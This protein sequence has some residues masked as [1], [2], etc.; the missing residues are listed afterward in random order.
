MCAKFARDPERTRVAI[1][2]A[3]ERLISTKGLQA[4]T[5]EDVA[6]GASIS[7]GGLLHHFPNK[8][9]LLTGLTQQ[10]LTEELDDIE[11]LLEKEPPTAGA[12]TRALLKCYL[13]FMDEGC[14][15]LCS[16]LCSELR[17]VPGLLQLIETHVE[18]I[19]ARLESDGLD[20]AIASIVA[21]AARG[22][23]SDFIWG[24]QRPKNFDQIV[25]R[26][27][28]LASPHSSSR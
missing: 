14:S 16:E 4:F 10:M 6:A 21:F 5:L 17:N 13:A 11:A 25:S 23:I 1:L 19:N 22:M 3:A 20:P 9:A 24:I 18:S 2:D 27:V 7:K 12:Y 8:V 26:L 28:E 15:R